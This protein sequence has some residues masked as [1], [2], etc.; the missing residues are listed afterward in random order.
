MG[1]VEL[2]GLLDS[3]LFQ[4]CMAF[5]VY[6][7]TV[8][9]TMATE[10][11]DDIV[12]YDNEWSLLVAVLDLRLDRVYYSGHVHLLDRSN[13]RNIPHILSSCQPSKLRHLGQSMASVQQ[14]RHGLYMVRSSELDRW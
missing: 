1:P 2:R 13:R 8:V 5:I 14:G 11:V 6:H 12:Q 3:R 7:Q 4:Y 9:L 10:H